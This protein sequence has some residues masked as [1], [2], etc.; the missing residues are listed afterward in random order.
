M[1]KKIFKLASKIFLKDFYAAIPM[2]EHISIQRCFI[3]YKHENTKRF[4]Q[5]SR[6]LCNF[7]NVYYI[8]RVQVCN[9]T[10]CVK[11]KKAEEKKKV[12]T[13]LLL[14]FIYSDELILNKPP[15]NAQA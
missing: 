4:L 11:N 1:P 2:F 5:M 9:K 7:L 6:P 13:N 10:I 15:I 12:F 3:V 8:L 14:A